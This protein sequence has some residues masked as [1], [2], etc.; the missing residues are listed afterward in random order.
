M[1]AWSVLLIGQLLVRFFIGGLFVSLFAL[2]G[3]V[4]RP[5]SFAGLFSAAPSVALATLL[6]AV[7]K[8][9]VAYAA[10]EARSAI[11]GSAAF[12]L[13]AYAA[14]VVFARYRPPAKSATAALLAVWFV[15]A[16]G[17]WYVFIARASG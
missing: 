4:L 16:F 2:I 1:P 8:D 7:R 14:M 12:L 3:T 13:Y 11:L 6:L 15:V 9:G 5:K 10:V 17:L